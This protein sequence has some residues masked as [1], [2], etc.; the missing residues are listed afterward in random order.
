[1][2]YTFTVGY[3]FRTGLGEAVVVKRDINP[4]PVELPVQ[5]L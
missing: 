1:M 2:S 3:S 5:G 4:A